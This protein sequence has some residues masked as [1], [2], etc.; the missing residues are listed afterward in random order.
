MK[1][2]HH[3]SLL[4]VEPGGRITHHKCALVEAFSRDPRRVTKKDRTII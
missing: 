4:V 1:E 2:Q 3:C